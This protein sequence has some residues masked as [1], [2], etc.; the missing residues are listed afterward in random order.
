SRSR[1][2]PLIPRA[3]CHAL[4]VL[5]SRRHTMLRRSGQ[6]VY[7]STGRTDH[8]GYINRLSGWAVLV[9]GTAGRM[10]ASREVS[11]ADG[12]GSGLGGAGGGAAVV[13]AGALALVARGGAA[14]ADDSLPSVPP[15]VGSLVIAD[16]PDGLAVGFVGAGPVQDVGAFGVVLDPGP[17]AA[18]YAPA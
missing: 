6:L 10:A 2:V 7:E 4:P 13:A 8:Q 5:Q 16:P 15:P 9:R 12:W 3:S 11:M 1:A 14:R 18:S 17:A